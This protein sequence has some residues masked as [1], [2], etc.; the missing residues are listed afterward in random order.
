[1]KANSDSVLIVIPSTGSVIRAPRKAIG[2]PRLTQKANRKRRNRASTMSTR[3]SPLSPFRFSVLR[4]PRSVSEAS[5]QMVSW[6]P[7]GMRL[8]A[9]TT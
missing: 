6:M 8:W 1:M 3:I 7:S 4:R 5:F 9:S 2:T